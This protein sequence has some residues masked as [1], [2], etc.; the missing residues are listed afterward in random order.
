[1][2][3][4]GFNAL[5]GLRHIAFRTVDYESPSFAVLKLPGLDVVEQTCWHGFF[6][7]SMRLFAVVDDALKRA[8]RLTMVDVA[9]LDLLAKSDR[10]TF[11]H[12]QLSHALQLSPNQVGQRIRHLKAR[13]LVTQSPTS[14]DRRGYYVTITDSGRRRLLAARKAFAEAVSTHY[15]NI[16]SHQQMTAL[17]DVHHRISDHLRA[18]EPGPPEAPA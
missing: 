1:V 5:N 13:A 2:G 4:S 8:H 15:L 18:F 12:R 17:A 7:T 14:Y 3:R 16:L 10:G 11:P 9:L 6:G